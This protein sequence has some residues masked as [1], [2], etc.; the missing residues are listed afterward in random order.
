VHS[1][2]YSLV[3][4]VEAH[5]WRAYHDIRR[6]VLFEARGLFGV[7]DENR[8]DERVVGNHPKL[9]RHHDDVVG[10]VRIDVAG[11]VAMI[12]R[13]AI[14]A[15]VQRHGH[16]RVLLAL[17]EEFA[18][19]QGCE[20]LASRVATDAVGFYRKCGFSIEPERVTGSSKHKVVFM[21]KPL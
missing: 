19:G 13:V 4:P 16:G 20:R 1:T 17:V 7:Y 5:E 2:D 15:D 18:R 3:S 12:R 11:T 8:P 6:R 14:R 10:V 9:L 21:T